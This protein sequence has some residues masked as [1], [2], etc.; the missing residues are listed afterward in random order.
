[1]FDSLGR[2]GRAPCTGPCTCP[3]FVA[4]GA[5][6][7]DNGAVDALI[8]RESELAVLG[9]IVNA[10]V[11]GR[12][13]AVLI[14]G[15]A[16]IGKTRLLVPARERAASAGARV[17]CATA[18]EG[19]ARIPL[20]AAR[21]LLARAARDVEIDEPASVAARALDGAL[22]EPS[23]PGSRADEVV[24]ALWWLIVELAD[25]EP[26]ALFLDDAQWADELT[27]RLLRTAARRAGGLP[28]ALVVAAR[29]AAPGE[30][31]AMLAAERAFARLEPA[32]LSA[33]GTARLFEEV[34]GQAGSVAAIARART[35]T[36][37]NP[38]YLSELLHHTRDRG[39][40]LSDG[41]DG[42]APPQLVR[43]VADRLERLAPAA[44]ALAH[45]VAVLG[46]DAAPSRARTL[47][48][49]DAIDAIA[50][51]ETLRAE[52]V[53]DADAYAFTHPLVAAAAREGM[54]AKDAAAL[55]A[56]AA[57]LLAAEGVDDQRVA[58]HLMRAPPRGDPDVVAT[59]RAAAE[60][61]RRLGAGTSSAQLLERALAEPPAPE[62]VDRVEFER[63]RALLDAGDEEGVNVLRR[64]LRRAPEP[65][66]QVDAARHLSLRLALS[67]RSADA[68]AVLRTV[69]AALGDEQR[70]MRLELLVDLA[71]IAGSENGRD[72]QALQAIAVE[73]EQAAGRTPGER[74]LSA[75]VRMYG[76]EDPSQAARTARE[77]LAQRL[78]RDDRGGFAVGSVTFWATATLMAADALGDAEQAMD[79]L[80]ADAEAAGMPQLIA[81]AHWQHAQIAY[82]GGEL[83]RC[84]LE[85][86]AAIEAGGD[87]ARRLATPWL[88]MALSEQPR[89]DE[90]ERL[91]GA[92]GMLG[93][94][95]PSLLVTAALG[96]RGRLRLAQADPDRAVA[97]LAAIVDRNAA[98]GRERVEPPW[99]PLLTE[100]LV[101]AGRAEE[102]S[103]VAA[104]YGELAER[105]GTPRAHG[106]VARLRALLAPRARAI[107]LLEE[108]CA[109][110]TASHA[111]LELA[112]A[113]AEL[114]AHR[115][116][117]GD[118]R[119]ARA[120]LRDAHEVAHA[121]HA[122]ALCERSRAELLL[123]GGR[124]R[125]PAGAGAGALTPAERRVAE[126]AAQGATNREIARRLYLS[127][128]TIE[129]HLRS[130]Y[131]KLDLAG[132]AGLAAA[133]S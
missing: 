35:V 119:A 95:P 30:P 88:A 54:R 6:R 93:E 65:T 16:G 126:L 27:L 5:C 82:Q 59:L 26:L 68:V 44:A 116:A 94:I 70:E 108:A 109:H 132:R 3:A 4:A 57:A 111:R 41:L 32:P 86:S 22:S 42:G 124:P 66:L 7:S 107:P 60:T 77:M 100:A 1:M 117:A 129:M 104:V 79:G 31:H 48:G 122:T 81:G 52:R 125:P 91:L 87:F 121:C 131:R 76:R 84:E 89:L 96:S 40:D 85:A 115:R 103:E 8:E 74:M 63:G 51:E 97:D 38:L 14:E 98:R 29:P 83:A 106:H 11:S 67:G 71:F 20:A 39:T 90:A 58:E 128:K 24:H 130:T 21:A 9:E 55:H 64:L 102:A 112:R 110:F 105:W 78:H 50:A 37:G 101:L 33:A 80:L 28:L 127:P 114:G 75:T 43:L 17:L 73:A 92:A 62:V 47:A 34:V 15:E 123:A 53:L 19:E 118:R 113:L 13:A 133:L 72:E 12:G 61:A 49:L 46:S 36:G 45:A 120:I 23:G 69:L 56:R 99:R 10:A 25:V 18:E 2:D